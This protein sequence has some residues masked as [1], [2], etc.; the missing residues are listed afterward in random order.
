MKIFVFMVVFNVLG[1]IN[2]V[3]ELVKWVYDVGV[4]VVIDVV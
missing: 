4:V 2:F 3:E 1:M